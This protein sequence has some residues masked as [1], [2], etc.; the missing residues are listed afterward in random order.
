MT[1]VVVGMSGGVDSSMTAIFLK[2][3][4]CDIIA[5]HFQ[6]FDFAQTARQINSEQLSKDAKDVK[7][8]AERFGLE[9]IDMDMREIFKD[10]IIAKF[11]SEYISG[12]TPNPCVMCNPNIKM[13]TLLKIADEYSAEFIATGHYV[14][15]KPNDD[16]SRWLLYRCEYLPKDQSYYL[17]QLKQRH[18]SRLLAPLGE[19][20]K[21]EIVKKA[22]MLKLPTAEKPESQEICFIR[23]NDYRKY[24]EKNVAEGK[25]KQG[26]IV[27][28]NGKVLGTHK[29][30]PY[31]TI[32]QRK[33]LNI[34]H[35]EPLYVSGFNMERNELIVG[36]REQTFFHSLTATG[37]NWI[38]FEKPDSDFS[39]E[40]QV[41]YRQ[42]PEKA[43][44]KII[45]DEKV[46][47]VFEKEIFAP[48]PGQAVVF[49]KEDM[50]LGG[51]WIADIKR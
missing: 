42:K 20:P 50:C 24:L 27:N 19:Y 4:G 26:N 22:K 31:Y 12:R 14:K 40:V 33:G 48:A 34:S 29:G 35:S 7:A 3:T 21:S 43:N 30:L 10:K 32:G 16:K 5:V 28:I 6:M 44:I 17:S 38:A 46:E 18:L 47:V 25:I 9:F 15:V 41:R 39:C 8:I 11:I 13:D 1:K 2:E 37:V 23:D 51:G 45:N 49:Y 36:E